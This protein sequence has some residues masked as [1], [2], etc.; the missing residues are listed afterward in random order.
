MVYSR[1][2]TVQDILA[3]LAR[4]GHRV[5]P[6][7][8]VSL[9]KLWKLMDLPTTAQRRDLL[10]ERPEDSDAAGH[11]RAGDTQLPHTLGLAKP[12]AATSDAASQ[13]KQGFTDLDLLR[14]QCFFTKL[15]LLFDDPEGCE[16]LEL[17]MGQ[18]GLEPLRQM[19]FGERYRTAEEV[20]LLKMRYDA[21]CAWFPCLPLPLDEL[22]RENYALGNMP[23]EEMG[24]THMEH[25]GAYYNAADTNTMGHLLRPTSLVEEEVARRR[26]SLEDD[27]MPLRLW[28]NVDLQSGPN[29]YPSSSE[30]YMEDAEYKLRLL[31][32]SHH[33]GQVEAM[34]ARFDSPPPR[35]PS[36][37]KAAPD[38]RHHDIQKFDEPR[39]SQNVRGDP[40][41]ES[42]A[43][44]IRH[45]S[46][47]SEISFDPE[48]PAMEGRAE[49]DRL[50]RPD[51]PY[52]KSPVRLSAWKEAA[53]SP[54][55]CRARTVREVKRDCVCANS[56]IFDKE[57][58][59]YLGQADPAAAA[60]ALANVPNT[61]HYQDEWEGSERESEMSSRLWQGWLRGGDDGLGDG[62]P[63]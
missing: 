23:A 30:M 56:A 28:G 24:K 63:S 17:T 44:N 48:T 16:L 21:G 31:D 1:E 39:R 25:W 7:T 52:P 51:L 14:I 8:A 38:L 50:R 5:P 11:A 2:H 53:P 20:V 47:P 46:N 4:E 34:K 49:E 40:D 18:R 36:G 42:P 60:A 15:V 62:A 29:L 45:G 57:S 54:A 43:R 26:L 41:S 27:L 9:L 58:P 33:L 59:M 32:T 61:I 55:Q 22:V 3:L 19:L 13:S 37:S 35:A 10:A 6:G 12:V